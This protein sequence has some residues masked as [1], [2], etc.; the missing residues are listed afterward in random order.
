MNISTVTNRLLDA[1]R[2]FEIIDCHEHLGPETRRLERPVDLFTLF[3]HYT[4]GDLRVAGMS[5]EDYQALFDQKIPLERRWMLFKPYW[6][7]IRW[8]SYARAA[9]IAAEK[10]YGYS[11]INDQTYQ[12]LS[13]AIQKANQPGIYQRVLGDACKIRTALTLCGETDLGTPLLTPLMPLVFRDEVGSWDKLSHPRFAPGATIRCMDDYL[14]AMREYVLRVKKQ[15]AVGLK[16]H[17]CPFQTPDRKEA[18]NTF[19]QLRSGRL[20]GLP[21]L[22]ETNPF[23]DYLVDQ[24]I[25]FAGEQQLVVAVHTG[26]WGDFRMLD[27]LHII[28]IIQRHPTVR[29]DVY[30]LGFP[31][32]REALM[33]GKGFP[34]V[35]LNLCWTHI[36]SQRMVV[37]A[38]DEAIDLLPTN[39]LLAF[40][41]DYHIP[42]EKVYEHLVMAQENIALV[43]AKRVV[44]H[45]MTENQALELAHRWFWDN[46]VELYHLDV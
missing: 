43:L 13:E 24:M 38:L 22:P 30:H 5:E 12:P 10:F 40:G 46:P 20:A 17:S 14:D 3:S 9:L 8:T 31:W 34:N 2:E 1:I 15:G 6:E 29:F 28:P 36:I 45:Q 26:Y 44:G 32:V 11:D 4:H 19:E 42:V 7:R 27:P 37:S 21:P 18:I 33:M 25:A 39:K 23:L 41:G 35:W 16:M